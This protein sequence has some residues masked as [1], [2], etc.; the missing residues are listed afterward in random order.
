MILLIS[1][2]LWPLER[3]RIWYQEPMI[4]NYESSYM[5]NAE[6]SHLRLVN[7]KDL[8]LNQIKILF[9]DYCP[10]RLVRTDNVLNIRKHAFNWSIRAIIRR[11]IIYRC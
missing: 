3:R 7:P 1:S 6:I 11:E 2:D 9:V 4:N 8:I 10:V 5:K